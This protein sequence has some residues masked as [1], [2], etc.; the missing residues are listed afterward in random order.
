[1]YLVKIAISYIKVPNKHWTQLK[2][3]Y[4]NLFVIYSPIGL[5]YRLNKYTKSLLIWSFID[6][7]S[8]LA[9]SA[10]KSRFKSFETKIKSKNLQVKIRD[11]SIIDRQKIIT[12]YTLQTEPERNFDSL[13]KS[14]GILG[15]YII[16]SLTKIWH[17]PPF[18]NFLFSGIPSHVP[19][20]KGSLNKGIPVWHHSSFY[21]VLCSPIWPILRVLFALNKWAKGWMGE[22]GDIG[23]LNVTVLYKISGIRRN[24]G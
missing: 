9:I 21:R 15:F 2:N 24:R 18:D 19:L 14:S 20:T 5:N 17:S 10:K 23:N 22:C 1:M 16:F 8:N 3:H 7:T 6:H 13:W 11:F 4:L 12:R